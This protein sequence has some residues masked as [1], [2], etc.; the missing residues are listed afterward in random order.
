MTYRL[1]GKIILPIVL[2]VLFLGFYTLYLKNTK[3]HEEKKIK[4]EISAGTTNEL[5][6]DYILL[7]SKLSSFNL[8]NNITVEDISGKKILLSNI[9]ESNK[10][11][12]YRISESYCMECIKAQFPFLNILSEKLGKKHLLLLTSFSSLKDFKIFMQTNKISIPAYN[13]QQADLAYLPIESLNFPYYF[14]SNRNNN[15]Q[16]VFIPQK[17]IP[18]LSDAYCREII[19]NF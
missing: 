8:N 2:L 19:K 6:T 13:I 10:M 3:G 15:I 7:Q 1:P 5:L 9:L 12:V 16:Y 4:K 18:G 17:E 11:I 14:E